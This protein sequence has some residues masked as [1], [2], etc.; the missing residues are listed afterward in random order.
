MVTKQH[1][2]N[3]RKTTLV[4]LSFWMK[5]TRKRGLFYPER[6]EKDEGY[7]R[8]TEWYIKMGIL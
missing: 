8:P 4:E 6:A 1:C 7:K 5:K 3:Q 2:R